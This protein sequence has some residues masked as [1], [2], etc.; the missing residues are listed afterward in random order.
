M[1]DTDRH[2]IRNGSWYRNWASSYSDKGGSKVLVLHL[3]LLKFLLTSGND[4]KADTA[5]APAQGGNLQTITAEGKTK[6]T[7]GRNSTWFF[8]TPDCTAKSPYSVHTQF[9]HPCNWNTWLPPVFSTVTY[10]FVHGRCSCISFHHPWGRTC[11]LHTTTYIVPKRI[12]K[13][14]VNTMHCFKEKC[15]FPNWTQFL[16]HFHHQME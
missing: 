12:L 3:C 5:L 4:W 11:I 10:L 6:S 14:T 2:Q 8:C 15:T 7:Q 13:A 16:F 1:T 9:S